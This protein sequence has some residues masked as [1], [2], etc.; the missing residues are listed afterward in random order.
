MV[1]DFRRMLK[2]YRWAYEHHWHIR[3]WIQELDGED[4][5]ILLIFTG[6]EN[7]LMLVAIPLL[8][9][10]DLARLYTVTLI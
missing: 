6:L 2:N 5:Y 9:C 3:V 7:G 10:K 4:G 1:M 8:R